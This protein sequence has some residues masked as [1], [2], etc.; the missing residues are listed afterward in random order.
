MTAASILV[1]SPIEGELV[2]LRVAVGDTVQAGDEMAI[3]EFAKCEYRLRAPQS[4]IVSRV[5]VVDGFP[6]GLGA[7]VALIQP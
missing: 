3:L 1:H 4:G 5:L 2:G 6:V 7:A